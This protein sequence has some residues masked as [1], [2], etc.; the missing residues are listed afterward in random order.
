MDMDVDAEG[1]DMLEGEDKVSERLDGG[2]DVTMHRRIEN[3][4]EKGK[5]DWKRRKVSRKRR[6]SKP[7]CARR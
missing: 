6:D 4:I 3:E 2:D 7:N 5:R 1:D